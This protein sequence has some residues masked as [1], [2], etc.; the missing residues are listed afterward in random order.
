[1]L[2]NNVLKAL[3]VKE[4]GVKTAKRSYFS[5]VSAKSDPNEMQCFEKIAARRTFK[6]ER[7]EARG[8]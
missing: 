5:M 8:P 7:S 3:K 2:G 6:K 4:T 1:M